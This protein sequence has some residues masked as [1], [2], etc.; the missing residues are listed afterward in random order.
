MGTLVCTVEMSKTS[1]ITVK[2]ENA[3]KT[4]TQT[5]TMDGETL[6][7]KVAGDQDTSTIVQKADS[8]SITCKTFQITAETITCTSTKAS[9]YESSE[10]ELKLSSQKDMSF[11][12]AAKLTQ[13]ATG[14]LKASGANVTIS[15]QTKT[16]ISAMNVEVA[17]DTGLKLTG[18]ANAELAGSMVKIQ[19]NATLSAESS[20]IAT[21]KGSLTNIQGSLIK[22]G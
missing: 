16:K 20:G 3:D 5:I 2:V 4:I 10:D 17:G 6:T 11:T 1:G 12:S 22:A 13:S 15:G 14:D 18:S 8:I 7:I 9:K 21:L 19:A